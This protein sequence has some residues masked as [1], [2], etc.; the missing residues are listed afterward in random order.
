MKKTILIVALIVWMTACNTRDKV[1]IA[2][3]KKEIEQR[4]IA[5]SD[6]A[7]AHGVKEAFLEFAHENAVLNRNETIISGKEGI[8]Q[9]FENSPLINVKLQW[10][11]TFVDVAASGD[12]AYTYGDYT[13]SALR[14]DSVEI[15][16]TGIFHT[17][18]KKNAKGEWKFV[19]D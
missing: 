13:F 17:V 1:D 2:S 3:V 5:F 8:R 19:Y 7:A 18:W 12:M 11:P 15:N 4:E 16:A 9:Y 14:P 10:R 6:Y